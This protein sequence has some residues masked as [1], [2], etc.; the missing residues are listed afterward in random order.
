MVCASEETSLLGKKQAGGS[1]SGVPTPF[2]QP[3]REALCAQ[4][5][6]VT[7]LSEPPSAVARASDG[8][9]GTAVRSSRMSPSSCPCPARFRGESS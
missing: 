7:V 8:A 9:V 5:A 2:I 3:Q 6:L 1:P 4:P